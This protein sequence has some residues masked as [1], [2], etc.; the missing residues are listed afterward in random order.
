MGT[1][2]LY[3][4]TLDRKKVND[5]SNFCPNSAQNVH[6]VTV[7]SYGTSATNLILPHQ[8]SAQ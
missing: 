7:P 2:G 1:S 3:D 6:S 5:V 8:L 4:D